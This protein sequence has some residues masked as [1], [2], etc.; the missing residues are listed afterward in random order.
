MDSRSTESGP[1]LDPR[2]RNDLGT[3]EMILDSMVWDSRW[4]LGLETL[5][6]VWTPELLTQLS[7]YSFGTLY[8]TLALWLWTMDLT[9]GITNMG[10]SRLEI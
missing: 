2:A 10:L 6:T 7:C 9:L 5:G 4:I 8:L 1:D 3:L